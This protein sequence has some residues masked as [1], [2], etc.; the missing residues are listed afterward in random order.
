[1]FQT[2]KNFFNDHA[3]GPHG[4]KNG[5]CVPLLDGDLNTVPYLFSSK[6]IPILN[7]AFE[8]IKTAKRSL[9]KRDQQGE[10]LKEKLDIISESSARIDALLEGKTQLTDAEFA[11]YYFHVDNI[12][13]ENGS[14]GNVYEHAGY[15]ECEDYH[16]KESLYVAPKREAVENLNDI[17]AEAVRMTIESYTDIG[18]FEV[19]TSLSNIGKILMTE[20][21][22][23]MAESYQTRSNE[24]GKDRKTP[25]G[26]P[27][28]S[29]IAQ[30]RSEIASILDQSGL[31]KMD[32]TT[33]RFPEQE[34]GIFDMRPYTLYTWVP[35]EPDPQQSFG[36][37]Q[38]PVGRKEVTA[39][40]GKIFTKEILENYIAERKI[41]EAQVKV[42]P[43]HRSPA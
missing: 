6:E 3:I 11:Q 42:K 27:L 40:V 23:R 7:K 26:N 38:E 31:R 39:E 13:K 19:N 17:P 12:K 4:L 10:E 24:D 36:F 20:H 16:T 43:K 15:I 14:Y 41:T 32:S 25:N 33:Q 34:I 29:V 35:K 5:I 21:S 37:A 30:C 2:I 28:D 18:R 9:F 8:D 22:L 1:M